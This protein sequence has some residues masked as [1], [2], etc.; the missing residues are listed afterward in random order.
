MIE[1]IIC[2]ICKKT[3]KW[4]DNPFRPFCSERCKLIDLG[5]WAMEDYWMPG[6]KIEEEEKEKAGKENGEN[7]GE[8]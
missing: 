8:E 3:A 6:E 7:G 2:P 4:K 1:K 5:R